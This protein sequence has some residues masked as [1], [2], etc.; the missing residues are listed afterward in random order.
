MHNMDLKIVIRVKLTIELFH[1]KILGFFS[2]NC[3]KFE[4][5]I[6]LRTWHMQVLSKTELGGEVNIETD[7]LR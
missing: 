1:L 2:I 6:K 3:I 4:I 7:N 5:S